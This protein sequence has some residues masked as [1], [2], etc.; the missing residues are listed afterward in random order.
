M[1]SPNNPTDPP[2]ER[3]LPRTSHIHQFD[4]E[5]LGDRILDPDW[6]MRQSKED[7]AMLV[8]QLARALGREVSRETNQVEDVT[9]SIPF[10]LLS[11]TAALL[12]ADELR[13]VHVPLMSHKALEDIEATRWQIILVSA[14]PNDAPL[15]LYVEDDV[16]VGRPD[17]TAVPDLDLTSYG[18][19]EFG[20]SRQHAMLRPTDAGLLVYDLG[21]TNGTFSNGQRIR[22]GSPVTVVNND[23]ISFGKLHL[24]LKIIRGPGQLG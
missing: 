21:S 16:I 22:L 20:V 19:E 4:V 23:V 17:E 11:D 6:L 14:N 1:Q 12:R 10:D 13:F 9:H 2:S 3:P 8:I 7:L 18:A 15:G 5:M 24:K